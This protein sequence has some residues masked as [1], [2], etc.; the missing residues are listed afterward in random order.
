MR[1]K[2]MERK[3]AKGDCLDV[4][5]V[6]RLLSSEEVEAEGL[7]DFGTSRVFELRGFVE[8]VDY[9]DPEAEDW[10]RSIARRESDDRIFASTSPDFY[11][12]PGFECLWL[13]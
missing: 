7:G 3:L 9:A 5:K 4:R 13:R 12:R 1:N 8:D 10:I 11:Q 2:A 6:G